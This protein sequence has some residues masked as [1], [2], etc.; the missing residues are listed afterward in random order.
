MP[1]LLSAA[2]LD[3]LRQRP[4]S[5]AGPN[6]VAW[7]ATDGVQ[8]QPSSEQAFSAVES[9]AVGACPPL[10]VSMVT[11]LVPAPLPSHALATTSDLSA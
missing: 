11:L 9:P 4:I 7:R 2:R 1:T 8:W 6:P 10:P 5:D 3:S